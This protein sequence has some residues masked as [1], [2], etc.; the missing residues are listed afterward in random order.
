MSRD[1]YKNGRGGNRQGRGLQSTRPGVTLVQRHIEQYLDGLS[2]PE[3]QIAVRP[4]PPLGMP[5]S[6]TEH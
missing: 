5:R 6:N 2:F 4:P 3:Q 1:Q